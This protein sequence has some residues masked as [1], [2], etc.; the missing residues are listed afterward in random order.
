MVVWK[1]G[2]WH[3][4]LLT[5]CVGCTVKYSSLAEHRRK[6]LFFSASSQWSA[7]RLPAL[8]PICGSGLLLRRR[9][10]SPSGRHWAHLPDLI[11]L[12]EMFSVSKAWREIADRL[13][14]QVE[15]KWSRRTEGN[16]YRL[17]LLLSGE[18]ASA[19]GPE[20]EVTK[21]VVIGGVQIVINRHLPEASFTKEACRKYMQDDMN[22]K[23]NLG[24]RNFL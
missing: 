2:E 19:G 15:G 18:N 16:A 10:V 24:N 22:S 6:F 1:S 13:C 23:G 3:P 9:P 14:L 12:E 21:S 8:A 7:P 5:F 4:H 11:S 20:G 17:L